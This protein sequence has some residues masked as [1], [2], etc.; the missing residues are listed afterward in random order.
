MIPTTVNPV[1]RLRTNAAKADNASKTSSTTMH[2]PS[3]RWVVSENIAPARYASAA[4][5]CPSTFSPFSAKKMQ[6][7]VAKRESNTGALDT[8]KSLSQCSWPPTNKAISA[9]VKVI[10]FCPRLLEQVLRDHQRD[11]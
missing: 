2:G 6:P 11:V 8:N 3:I 1:K 4:K 9:A 7:G 10:T 5:S